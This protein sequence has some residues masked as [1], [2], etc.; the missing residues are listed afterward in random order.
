[1]KFLVGA[2]PIVAFAFWLGVV[3]LAMTFVML[4]VTVIMRQISLRRE[5]LDSRAAALWK[6]IVVAV[7]SDGAAVIPKLAD[8]DLFGF[9]RVWNEVHD[10]LHGGT[11]DNLAWIAREVGLEQHLYQLLRS[12]IFSHR[13]VAVISLGHVAGKDSFAHV[14]HYLDDKSPI[15]SLCA[16]R[17]LMQIDP[18]RAAPHLIPHIVRRSDWSQGSI[19]TILQQTDAALVTG[20]LTEATVHANAETAPRLIR[21]L[22]IVS[23]ASAK[24]II[25]EAIRSSKDG[26]MVSTCLQVLSE[27]ADLE[28]VRPLLSHPR[29]HIRML[30]AVTLG[31]LGVS[32]DDQRLIAMLTDAQW[33]VRYRA[34]QALLNLR[35]VSSEQMRR[36]QHA[37]TDPY[38]RDIIKHVLAERATAPLS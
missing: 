26:R 34:A 18:A 6:P 11:T 35:F 19:A 28:Y 10:P 32:G 12:T 23:P 25:R 17:A 37:Q 33:W 36:I 3:V 1:M 24:P 5:R 2:A 30:A 16:A 13:V 7:P 27:P 15:L 14:L 4:A 38:A 20:P 21:F 8:R 22:A 31:R 29:W 9:A